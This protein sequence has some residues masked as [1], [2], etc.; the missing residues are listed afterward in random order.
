MY[1]MKIRKTLYFAAHFHYIGVKEQNESGSVGGLIPSFNVYFSP[2][3]PTRKKRGRGKSPNSWRGR[4][5]N[6]LH[7]K[8]SC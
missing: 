6:A 1:Y 7:L 3:I 4:V 8:C 2:S 5:L